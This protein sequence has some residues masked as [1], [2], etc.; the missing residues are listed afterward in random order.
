M[1]SPASNK[2]RVAI[3]G[4][5]NVAT[6]LVKVL[7][8]KTECELVNPRSLEGWTG[9]AHV[10]L[11]AVSDRA[12]GE[13]ASHLAPFEGIMAHTSGS[14]AI[15][16]LT[17]FSSRAGVLYPLQTF[18]KGS[19]P[20]YSKIPIFVETA[21]Q[22]D[23]AI[24]EHVAKMISSH[25]EKAD[26]ADRQ[27]LHLAS[28]MACNFTNHLMALADEILKES[29]FSFDVLLPLLEETVRKLGEMPP[30]KAQTG[31]ASRKDM[32]VVQKHCEMLSS[33]PDI[34]DLYMQLSNSI[35]S[36]LK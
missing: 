27:R 11:I 36:H 22:E 12:I 20:D 31:P 24:L 5:G 7:I 18:S 30:A 9:T 29:G 21:R 10:A 34:K 13:V 8:G 4:T 32:D 28:V 26:S 33:H 23:L 19:H 35:I 14:V 16:S 25:V 3:V 6:H 2:L 15:N 17:Q 1:V